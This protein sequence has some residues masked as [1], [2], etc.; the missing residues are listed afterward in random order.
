[1]KVFARNC[2]ARRSGGSWLI[3]TGFWLTSVVKCCVLAGLL[4][5]SACGYLQPP[6]Y[7][8]KMT[9]KYWNRAVISVADGYHV[10]CVLFNKDLVLQ[11]L[12]L[13]SYIPPEQ[14][15]SFTEACSHANDP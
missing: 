9:W 7:H 15:V 8:G 11:Q 12:A 13:G 6:Q 3:V 4:I 10:S 5:V 14:A 1:M 2:I